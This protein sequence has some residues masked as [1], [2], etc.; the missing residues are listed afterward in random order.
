[1][2]YK[3]IIYYC[4]LR[5]LLKGWLECMSTVA[6]KNKKIV[7][8]LSYTSK[9]LLLHL[10]TLTD[11]LINN[12]VRYKTISNLKN[13]TSL[14]ERTISS[15]L[16]ELEKKGAIKVERDYIFGK[17][18]GV[19]SYLL[20]ARYD[21]ANYVKQKDIFEHVT[22]IS[23]LNHLQ[24]FIFFILL[25]NSDDLGLVKKVVFKELS[26]EIGVKE[27]T[28]KSNLRV[29]IDKGFLFD[30]IIS[31]D[32]LVFSGA[33]RD[34]FYINTSKYKFND[35]KSYNISSSPFHYDCYSYFLENFELNDKVTFYIESL[36]KQ[37]SIQFITAIVA[38]VDE[39]TGK[40]LSILNRDTLDKNYYITNFI[41][42]LEK[43]VF[44][45][46]VGR[47][48]HK[49]DHAKLAELIKL[50][51][52]Y[53][54]VIEDINNEFFEKEDVQGNSLP[55]EELV[56]DVIFLVF[57]NAFIY[58]MEQI[59]PID[60]Y[61]EVAIVRKY[62]KINNV[63]DLKGRGSILIKKKTTILTACEY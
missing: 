18:R 35:I 26:K 34:C 15:S 56:N 54:N 3:I 28:L 22:I 23:D 20:F 30:C 59:L 24:K 52:Y 10:S 63:R 21:L 62:L 12:V 45:F 14:S 42:H 29:L 6:L 2:Q 27:T 55:K 16:Q 57:N 33:S 38:I 43:E 31:G 7:S 41:K 13:I 9:Y 44:E 8:K 17:G 49:V 32:L 50:K 61:V 60:E 25:K 51:P 53:T 11:G 4:F 39:Y 19:N 47:R 5:K 40:L 48:L 36:A 46:K 37:P 58:F 1:M